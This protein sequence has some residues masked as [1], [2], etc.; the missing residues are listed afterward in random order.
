MAVEKCDGER[1]KIAAPLPN[2]LQL[3][4]IVKSAQ[5]SQKSLLNFA[6]VRFPHRLR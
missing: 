3:L 6:H 4:Q 2:I 1:S 5:F